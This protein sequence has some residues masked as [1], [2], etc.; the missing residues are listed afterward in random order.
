MWLGYQ[1][2]P[3]LVSVYGLDI[4]AFVLQNPNGALAIMGHKLQLSHFRL[5]LL[6]LIA[7]LL[8]GGPNHPKRFIAQRVDVPRATKALREYEPEGFPQPRGLRGLQ[9]RKTGEATV[10]FVHPYLPVMGVEGR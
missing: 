8:L 7:R 4:D 5:S 9:N 2:Q 6:A 10:V 3:S 1:N